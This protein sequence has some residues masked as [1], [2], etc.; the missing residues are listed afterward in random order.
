M[1]SFIN[2]ELNI[3]N[4]N[5]IE[6]I[7]N[8]NKNELLLEDIFINLRLLSKLE[9]GNKLIHNNKNLN[10]DNSYLQ[11]VTR[12]FNGNNRENNLIFIN[13]T[14][15]NAFIKSE[16]LISLNTNES[17]QLFLRLTTDLKNSIN[18][19][20]NLK[21]TYYYDKLI[22]SEIDVMI[23]NI[24][25]KLDLNFKN[26]N[27]S[28][29]NNEPKIN[30]YLISNINESKNLQNEVIN[31]SDNIENNIN[32]DIYDINKTNDTNEINNNNNNEID[33][34]N[35]EIDKPKDNN[36]N[37]EINKNNENDKTN[38][39]NKNNENDK[40]NETCNLNEF[41]NNVNDILENTNPLKNQFEYKKY[42]KHYLKKN[43][44]Q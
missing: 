32:N 16:K 21:Q 42:D 39:I 41:I 33:K 31:I 2:N 37:N 4:D 3:L 10:I 36:K 15:N 7:I 5:N 26:I 43:N 18:G 6:N 8:L 9:V 19:L 17:I 11:F 38:E 27:F 23:D 29:L 40:T 22:Q 34:P 14:L 44:L 13:Q 35:N 20:L 12:W 24:R 1:S 30:D 25:T 28:D